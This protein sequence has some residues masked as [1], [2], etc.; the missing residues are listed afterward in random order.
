MSCVGGGDPLGWLVLC[1]S[2]YRSLYGHRPVLF[3][4]AG[5]G[6]AMP[7]H[8]SG[9]C[10]RGNEK[11]MVRVGVDR[12]WAPLR[13]FYGPNH[14]FPRLFPN[15]HHK[16]GAGR[17]G[18]PDWCG[19]GQWRGHGAGVARAIG[20]FLGLGGA[21]VARAWRGRGAGM[22]CDPMEIVIPPRMDHVYP[23]M[24]RIS[25]T[26]TALGGGGGHPP[27]LG[28]RRG[29]VWGVGQK[30]GLGTCPWAGDLCPRG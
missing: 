30:N 2:V 3:R 13:V 20:I 12:G 7:Q 22:S 5:K 16:H 18:Q 10:A 27:P 21:G 23:R 8:C 25:T 15:L 19:S 29:R 6:D 4:N 11:H 24:S 28:R 17:A 26:Y 9:R 1:V 14:L